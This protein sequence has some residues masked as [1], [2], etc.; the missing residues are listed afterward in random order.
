M[1]KAKRIPIAA[2]KRI[3]EQYG[4]DQVIIV[5]RKIG[6]GGRQWHTTWGRNK[7]HCNAASMIMRWLE[8]QMGSIEERKNE[9]KKDSEAS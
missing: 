7:A 1:S 9:G 6:V 2:A 8:R 4:Y 5:A 3:G